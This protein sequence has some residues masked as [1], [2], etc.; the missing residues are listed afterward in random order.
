MVTVVLQKQGVLFPSLLY[1]RNL[2]EEQ[3]PKNN[4]ALNKQGSVTNRKDHVLGQFVVK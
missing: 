4:A 2:R 1:H 3:K